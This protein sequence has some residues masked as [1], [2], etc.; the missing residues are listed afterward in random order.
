MFIFSRGIN[1][2][3]DILLR[4]LKQLHLYDCL[5]ANKAM[6]AWGVEAGSSMRVGHVLGFWAE[7][8]HCP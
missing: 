8:G 2:M 7:D 1:Q 4:Q 6:M 3:E 5:R